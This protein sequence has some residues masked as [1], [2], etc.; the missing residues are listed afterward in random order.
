MSAVVQ[1]P[2]ETNEFIFRKQLFKF[3]FS[4]TTSNMLLFY[5]NTKL[6]L[7]LNVFKNYN[8]TIIKIK[9]GIWFRI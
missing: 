2:I 6:V 5:F 8:V 7:W 4:V 1:R 3:K 9:S